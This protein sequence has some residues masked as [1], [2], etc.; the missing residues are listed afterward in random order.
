M[1]AL[2]VFGT[3]QPLSS[4]L[5]AQRGNRLFQNPYRLPGVCHGVSTGGITGGDSGVNNSRQNG[6][7]E[8]QAWDLRGGVTSVISSVTVENDAGVITG[9]RADPH[10]R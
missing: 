6:S 4:Q 8:R 3:K 7:V 9:V 2:F 1:G 5:L 10:E